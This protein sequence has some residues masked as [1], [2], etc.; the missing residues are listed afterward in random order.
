MNDVPAAHRKLPIAVLIACCLL[1]AAQTL[2]AVTL[3]LVPQLT[4]PALKAL[5]ILAPLAV[6]RWARL[7]PA[8]ALHRIGL[9]RTR[10][11]PGLVTGAAMAAAILAL[12]YFVLRSTLQPV[13]PLIA[14]KI[15][16]LGLRNH[17]WSM[18]LVIA[19]ANSL[20]EEYYWR[21]FLLAEL[22]DRIP[23]PAA[24]LLA[25]CLFGLHHV[26]ALTCVHDIP[27]IALGALGTVLA[28]V[29]WGTMRVRGASLIDCYVSHILADLAA[30]WVGWDLISSVH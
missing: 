17:Y 1:P 5:M 14:E 11:A 9:H 28:G 20:L 7:R 18:V 29:I 30:L 6:W 12:Y 22:S 24:C 8:A 23:A 13:A 2:I 10:L 27:L 21:G 25:A 3:Q 26:F 4:Y 16:S 15:D 19:F